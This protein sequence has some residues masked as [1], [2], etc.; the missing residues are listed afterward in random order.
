MPKICLF[1]IG[2]IPTQVTATSPQDAKLPRLRAEERF[3]NV[4]RRLQLQPA[5]D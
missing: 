5:D 3:S 2:Q 1:R 4:N